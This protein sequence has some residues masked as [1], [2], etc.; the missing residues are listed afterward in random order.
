MIDLSTIKEMPTE[1]AFEKALDLVNNSEK[2]ILAT[3]DEKGFPNLKAMFNAKN[4]GMKEILFSTNTSSIRTQQ[5][6]NNE[7]ACVYFVDMENFIGVMLIGKIRAT[8]E[9]RLREMLWDDG[10]ERY[11]PLGINDPDYTVLQF[12]AEKGNIY[13]SMS[14]ADFTI[15]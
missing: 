15:Q 1:E 8:R 14:K 13:H 5:V 3:I 7:K 4:D 10:S 6:K 9:Q 2:C 11:Y 12:L